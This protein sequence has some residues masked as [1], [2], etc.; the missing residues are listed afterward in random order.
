MRRSPDE[1]DLGTQIGMPAPAMLAMPAGL[2]GIDRDQ[3]SAS[4]TESRQVLRQPAA[5]F[6]ARHE[7]RRDHGRADATVLVIMQVAAA[8]PHGRDVE[9]RF[10]RCPL[11]QVER[12]DA[13]IPRGVKEKGM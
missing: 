5:E 8:E 7:G 4:Q 3:R 1:D 12:R 11:A 6:M 10:A 2:I 13:G 9:Q